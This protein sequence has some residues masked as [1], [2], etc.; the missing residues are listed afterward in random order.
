MPVRPL[1]HEV[2]F[3]P[4]GGDGPLAGATA[5]LAGAVEVGLLAPGERLP[6]ERELAARLR[7]GRATLRQ[8]FAALAAS[9]HLITL[10]GRG[11]GTFAADDPPDPLAP[12]AGDRRALW[13]DRLAIETGVVAVAARRPDPQG[14]A[15]LDALVAAMPVERTGAGVHRRGDTRFHVALAETTGSPRLVAAMA[16]V[17]VAAAGLST[18][19]A[20]PEALARANAQHARLAAAIR[21]RDTP[22]AMDAIAAHL[23]EG[24]RALGL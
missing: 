11:G 3:A 8:A 14:L 19:P 21:A 15:I 24:E 5:R 18:V 17:H 2:L 20:D 16:A 7:V 23:H 4:V 1:L 12:A 10:R 9:G 13:D 22:R 6:P